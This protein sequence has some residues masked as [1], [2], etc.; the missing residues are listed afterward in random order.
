MNDMMMVP[1]EEWERLK[2]KHKGKV[3]Q[4]ALL[5]KKGRLGATEEVILANDNIPDSI[6]VLMT[7]P[8]AQQRRNLTKRLKT[9]MTGSAASYNTAPD[10]PEAM[11][12]FPAEDLI[13]RSLK[14]QKIHVTPVVGP[15]NIK[16]SPASKP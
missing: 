2:A 11:V 12:D 10:E 13:K 14:A 7:K 16:Q 3:A 5:D 15:S 9:G 8:L 1:A 4:N 6:V